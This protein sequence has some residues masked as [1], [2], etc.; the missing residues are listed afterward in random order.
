MSDAS[1]SGLTTAARLTLSGQ[2][3]RPGP[4]EPEQLDL[5]GLPGSNGQ[6]VTVHAAGRGSRAGIRNRRTQEW[7][8][9]LLSR[10]PSPLEGILALGNVPV[11][12]L[13]KS[14]SCSAKD[15]VLIKV[16][17]LEIATPYL[18]PKLQSVELINSPGDPRGSAA[19]RLIL[20]NFLEPDGEN[21]AVG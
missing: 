18:H 12:E 5:L 7:I 19:D 9:H 6:D 11:L 16:K 17:C 14:L 4:A 15:A 3:E 21:Q 2:P 20:E 8:D 13:C 10:Y 1:E